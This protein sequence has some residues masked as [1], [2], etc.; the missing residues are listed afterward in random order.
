MNGLID[1]I[2]THPDWD[3]G[4]VSGIS[5]S[6]THVYVASYLNSK[7]TVF[8]TSWVM[9]HSFGLG[10]QPFGLGATPDGYAWVAQYNGNWIRKY[11]KNQL[12]I[13]LTFTRYNIWGAL[14]A[15]FQAPNPRSVDVRR[16]TYL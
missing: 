8:T 12:I 3:Y 6:P 1:G 2:I 10:Y 16:C 4:G 9:V 7:V 5:F 14:Q 11:V 15:E 13:Y